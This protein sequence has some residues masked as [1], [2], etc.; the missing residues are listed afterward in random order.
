VPQNLCVQHA[1]GRQIEGEV[2]LAA[3]RSSCAGPVAPPEALREAIQRV[4][5][6]H[7]GHRRVERR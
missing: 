6:A 7:E 5:S 2:A 1:R 4:K 3:S